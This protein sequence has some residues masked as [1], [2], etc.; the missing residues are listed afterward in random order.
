[1]SL[2]NLGNK[3]YAAASLAALLAAVPAASAATVIFEDANGDGWTRNS[4]S[5]TQTTNVHSGTAA[6]QTTNGNYVFDHAGF[7]SASD[8]ILEFYANTTDETATSSLRVQLTWAGNATVSYDNRNVGAIYLVD[9]EEVQ[10]GTSNKGIALDT[11]PNTWQ[12]IQLDLSQVVYEGFPFV[13]HQYAPGVNAIT[14]IAFGND[15]GQSANLLL[16]SVRLVA[17]PE[18]ASLSVLGMGL[19]AMLLRRRR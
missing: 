5:S 6:L 16:D 19:G 3:S 4:Q 2:G 8:Y 9:G 15:G 14:K 11:D 13:S 18:P 12:L 17:V 10:A 1:M 7:T